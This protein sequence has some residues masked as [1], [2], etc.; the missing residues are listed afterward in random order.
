MQLLITNLSHQKNLLGNQGTEIEKR[1]KCPEHS[2]TSLFFLV[3]KYCLWEKEVG[4]T[5]L[6]IEGGANCLLIVWRYFFLERL[7]KI[8]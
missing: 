6:L 5:I 2:Q 1:M 3:K 8:Q 7:A 4:M